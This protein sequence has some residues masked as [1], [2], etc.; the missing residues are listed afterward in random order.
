M[1]RGY[2]L[3]RARLGLGTPW[4]GLGWA[5]AHR[6]LQLL[7]F[8]A[9]PGWH[10]LVPLTLPSQPVRHTGHPHATLPASQ[11]VAHGHGRDRQVGHGGVTCH[12]QRG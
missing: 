1:A 2:S 3:G 4:P 11:R 8:P 7:D 5:W 10:A 9:G 12:L 6:G